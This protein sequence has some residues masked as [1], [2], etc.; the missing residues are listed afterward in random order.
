MKTIKTLLIIIAAFVFTS[1]QKE[2]IDEHPVAPAAS[3][4]VKTYSEDMVSGG[5]H[6]S[7]TFNLSYDNDN[8]LVSMTSAASSGD[9]FE[10]HYSTD[11][12]SLDLYNSNTLSVHEEFYLNT[13]PF[14]DST[15]QYN[16]TGDSTTEKYIYNAG[17]QIITVKEYDYSLQTGAVLQNTIN[18]TYDNSGNVIKITD[19]Y[20][21]TTY[22]YYTGLV[23][24]LVFGLPY[25]PI[26]KDL[27][28]T[29]TFF[30]GDT[31][32]AHHVYTFDA[33]NRISTEKVTTDDG[34]VATK[35]YT[36]Y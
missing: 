21:Q 16:D 15:F 22:D 6:S 25:L 24:N 31:I 35:T 23:N 32:T 11:S 13:F 34:D 1:C 27:V 19:D 33:A 26:S 28:K 2:Y 10:Y 17:K 29:T 30:N 8:R 20:T 18:Y 36:Y 5:N 3:S 14:V 9:R 7:A 4:K 12:Y